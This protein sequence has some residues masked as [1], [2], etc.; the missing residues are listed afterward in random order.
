MKTFGAL[1]GLAAV[2]TFV[3]AGCGAD[4]PQQAPPG[5][6]G[7][8]GSVGAA[9]DQAKGGSSDDAGAS[10]GGS[11]AGSA[12][13]GGTFTNAGTSGAGGSN[14]GAG[15]GA[16]S[17]G[18]GGTAPLTFQ[19]KPAGIELV[20]D[21][22]TAASGLTLTTTSI[23]Q[24]TTGNLNYVEWLGELFNGSAE[25][26]CLIAVTGDFQTSG[27]LS[28]VKL[29]TYA[30]GPAY[31]LGVLS[32]SSPC[33][34]AGGRVPVWSN[35]IPEV[36][37]KIETIQKL[38]VS[39]EPLASPDAI[40]HPATPTLAPLT[41]TYSATFEAWQIASTATATADIYNASI[42]F[43]GKTGGFF[44]DSEKDFHLENFLAGQTWA[45]DTA[46]LGLETET[47]VEVIPYFSF[48]E[49]LK[50]G[51]ALRRVYDEKTS[52]M[53]ERRD[54]VLTSWDDARAN[55]LRARSA[56]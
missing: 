6:A 3:V 31:D 52:A 51:A 18:T 7:S 16:G 47:L 38:V 27:G 36:A 35:D 8:G 28:V 10:N 15:G 1:S 22:A 56:R 49:G 21:T 32:S 54:A 12:T 44:V 26:Q 45:I 19:S 2:L 17:G 20:L 30:Y 13:T 33:V 43:W 39:I 24:E 40:V 53:L 5:K 42:T 11:S 55:R 25:T 50:P 23:T 34:A 14:G 37:L 4:D 9:G 29:E 41:K 46:P 48:I